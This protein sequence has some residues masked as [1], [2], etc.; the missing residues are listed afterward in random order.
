MGWTSAHKSTEAGFASCGAGLARAINKSI[1]RY[2]P[3]PR[4]PKLSSTVGRMMVRNMTAKM[5][6]VKWRAVCSVEP[7]R[8]AS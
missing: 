5:F 1:A 2:G 6:V 4:S 8:G 3:A 7:E